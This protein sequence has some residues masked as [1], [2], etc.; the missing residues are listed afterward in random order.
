MADAEDSHWTGGAFVFMVIGDGE[1]ADQ[2]AFGRIGSSA[3]AG[4]FWLLGI[5]SD[6]CEYNGCLRSARRP[7]PYRI[8]EKE[9]F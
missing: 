6:C 1:V 7:A 5:G 9:I 8:D 2:V 3:S 4:P